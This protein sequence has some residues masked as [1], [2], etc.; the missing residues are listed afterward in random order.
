MNSKFLLTLACI[1]LCTAAYAQG[2]PS[3]STPRLMVHPDGTLLSPSNPLPVDAAVTIG[4]ITMDTNIVPITEWETQTLTLVANTAQD[5]VTGITGNRRFVALKS[6]KPD[7]EFWLAFNASA[8]LEAG[9]FVVDSV[10]IE[11]PKA[12]IVS[13]IASEAF[14]IS[15]TEGGD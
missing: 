1:L 5:L 11:V 6:H 8:T 7:K 9:M 14:K 15:V 3:P 4:S 2:V 12:T 13:V 10:Y